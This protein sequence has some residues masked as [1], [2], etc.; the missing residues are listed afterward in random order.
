MSFRDPLIGRQNPQRN[1]RTGMRVQHQ[2]WSVA[3]RPRL[4]W[5]WAILDYL[6]TALLEVDQGGWFWLNGNKAFIEGVDYD[7]P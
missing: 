1:D 5:W 2:A 7:N 4:P 6:Q 3:N